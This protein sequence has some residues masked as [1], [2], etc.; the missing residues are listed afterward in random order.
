MSTPHV[1]MAALIL[2]APSCLSAVAQMQEPPDEDTV[3]D[4]SVY[5]AAFVAL[6]L[7]FLLLLCICLCGGVAGFFL[8]RST[9]RDLKSL[10]AD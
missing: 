4:L 5:I 7:A 6:L 2:L 1:L 8:A 10:A 9:C 3:V